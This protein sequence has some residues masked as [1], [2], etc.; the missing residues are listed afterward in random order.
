MQLKR[1]VVF[2]KKHLGTFGEVGCLSF[3]GNKI[4]T[5]G[6]GGA[7]I[8]N[9]KK[10]VD[11]INHLANTAKIKHNWEYIHDDVGYNFKLPSINAALGIAQLE[12]LQ[13]FLK[14]KESYSANIQNL[15]I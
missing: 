1:L 8:T 4:I 3:N 14:A 15:K 5:T 12:K 9:K 11:R 2:I 6:E 7:V 10:L 13:I